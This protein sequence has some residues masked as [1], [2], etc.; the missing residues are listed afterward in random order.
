MSVAISSVSAAEFYRSPLTENLLEVRIK[1]QKRRTE[2]SP[3][4]WKH[5]SGDLNN[6]FVLVRTHTSV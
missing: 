5:Y 3:D 4:S 6:D 1:I 2:L